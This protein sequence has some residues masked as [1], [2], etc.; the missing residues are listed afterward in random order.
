[1]LAP[2]KHN[3]GP[4]RTSQVPDGALCSPPAALSGS[5]PGIRDGLPGDRH[6][7]CRPTGGH[8]SQ[9]PP[10]PSA[11]SHEAQSHVH[12]SWFPWSLSSPRSRKLSTPVQG[13]QRPRD[14]GGPG[15]VAPHGGGISPF[16]STGL[17]PME[18]ASLS[19]SPGLPLQGA[20]CTSPPAPPCPAQGHTLSASQQSWALTPQLFSWQRAPRYPSA[21]G[22]ARPRAPAGKEGTREGGGSAL[23]L[24]GRACPP[25][26]MVSLGFRRLEADSS[27]EEGSESSQISRRC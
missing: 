4:P 27:W 5:P 6:P 17:L 3:W 23:R 16:L 25:G 14:E 20:A 9:S 19:P 26:W 8:G 2:G 15:T 13:G 10:G 1:M 12:G 21:W 22:R 11:Q 7:W 18:P 24:Q